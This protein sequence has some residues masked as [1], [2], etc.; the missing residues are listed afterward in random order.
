MRQKRV[1]VRQLGSVW[2]LL[3]SALLLPVPAQ[4]EEALL[5][6]IIDDLGDHWNYGRRA[7]ELPGAV[8]YAVLPHTPY[9]RR[10]A[11]MANVTGRE[12]MLHQPMQAIN[13]K[14]MGP[15]GLSLDMT[16]E[17][18]VRTLRDNLRA[19]PHVSGVNNHM[20]SLLTRHP[21][22]MQWLMEELHEQGNLYFVDSRTSRQSVAPQLA[23]ES[24]LPTTQRN[25]FLDHDRDM[26]AI[27]RQFDEA[28]SQARSVGSSVLIGHPYPE[29]LAF[30]EQRLPDLAAEGVRL[31]P[32]SA[33]IAYRKGWRAPL[34]QAS[35]SPSPTDSK[36]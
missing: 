16:H 17:E 1:T 12:V 26:A 27:E 29:T 8:T 4:A 5:A 31:V 30:L 11:E 28:V 15:G 22:H 7:V 34:W 10:L 2:L 24:G 36:N 35:L 14:A 13:G 19:V 33:V 3:A 21:G 25:V 9:G 23:S 6:L 32:V 18:F 20:G